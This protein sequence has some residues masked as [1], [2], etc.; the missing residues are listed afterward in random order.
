MD[1]IETLGSLYQNRRRFTLRS[2]VTSLIVCRLSEFSGTLE[3]A[4]SR[5][6]KVCA[7]VLPMLY[8]TTCGALVIPSRYLDLYLLDVT[9]LVMITGKFFPITIFSDVHVMVVS[10]EETGRPNLVIEFFEV[11]ASR[12]K[13]EKNT[14][15][16]FRPPSMALTAMPGQMSG[17]KLPQPP[18][19]PAAPAYKANRTVSGGTALCKFG[20]AIA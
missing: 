19:G 1:R 10:L 4:L 3:G 5:L 13:C 8:Q 6:V 18:Y 17:L 15:C 20:S 2:R 9:P 12:V 14:G 7:T 16:F 11:S